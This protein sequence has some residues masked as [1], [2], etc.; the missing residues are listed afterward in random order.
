MR[1]LACITLDME[2]DHGDPEGRIRLLEDPRLFDRFVGLVNRH[3]GK[4]TMFTV[5]SLFGEIGEAFRKL[6]ER[7]PLQY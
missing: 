2:P 4:V 5:T 3:E 6:G 1:K 7:I